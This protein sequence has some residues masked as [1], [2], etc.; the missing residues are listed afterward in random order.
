MDKVSN[1][2]FLLPDESANTRTCRQLIYA[3]L[4]PWYR[5]ETAEDMTEGFPTTR[6]PEFDMVA[7]ETAC[8]KFKNTGRTLRRWTHEHFEEGGLFDEKLS[9][10]C[11][12]VWTF[13]GP[14]SQYPMP[15]SSSVQSI[16]KSCPNRSLRLEKD[17]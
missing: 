5:V 10:V 3:Q 13:W 8:M 12:K 7:L 15:M 16:Q 11:Q 4:F 1:K 14:S 2:T 6:S 9:T 17:V